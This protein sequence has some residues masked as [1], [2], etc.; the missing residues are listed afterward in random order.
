MISLIGEA[1]KRQIYKHRK[2]ITDYLGLE[3]EWGLPANG[4]EG[5]F[6]GDGNV[7][8]LDCSV[9]ITL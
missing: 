3:S 8:K 6:R 5:M 1:Q 7:V 9:C 2:E 4:L